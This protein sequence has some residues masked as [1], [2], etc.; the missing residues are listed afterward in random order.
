M[1]GLI[2]QS[3]QYLRQ[4]TDIHPKIGIILGSG[5]GK[6][7]DSIEQAQV[8]PYSDI[9]N[10]PVSTVAGHKGNLVF[11]LLGGK[12][13][14]VMQGRFHYYEGYSMKE[15][16]FPVRVMKELGVETLVV[17]NAAGCVN[18]DFA[19]GDIMLVRDHVNLFPENPLRG[20]NDER[21]GIRFPDM[22]E[23]YS[24]RLRQLAKDIARRE[25]L[26]LREGIYLG[27]QGPSFETPAEYRMVRALGC[28]VVGM[29]T[30]PEVI[31]ARHA[32][33][34]VLAL[35]V[36][37]NCASGDKIAQVTHEEVQ[38]AADKAQKNMSRLVSEFI[39]AL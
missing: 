33:I 25:G 1:Y 19:V 17:S 28:D 2:Q 22:S 34:E 38:T 35:S 5:L 3:A 29:S 36:I 16:T 12:E 31:V 6:L 7:A 27:W 11:G 10:F 13:V 39:Q 15:V 8:I 23:A 37:T 20:H 21:M 14:M 30:V 4:Q 24:Q 9:P 18:P 26:L 32:Q